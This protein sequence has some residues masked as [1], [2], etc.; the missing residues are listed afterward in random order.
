MHV[1]KKVCESI[2]GTLLKIKGKKRMVTV[3]GSI[4]LLVNQNAR[5]KQKMMT[6]SSKLARVTISV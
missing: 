4:C 5:V 6:N 3:H 1:E 2:L